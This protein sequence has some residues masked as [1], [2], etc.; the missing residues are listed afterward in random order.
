M[1]L[2]VGPTERR[3]DTTLEAAVA[4][5]TLDPRSEA[6]YIH[7]MALSTVGPPRQGTDGRWRITRHAD[8]LVALRHPAL[9]VGPRALERRGV[10]TGPLVDLRRR[11]LINLNGS[12]HSLLRRMIERAFTPRAVR[13]MRT[14]IDERSRT[15]VAAFAESAEFDFIDRFAFRLPITVI[16]DMLGLDDDADTIRTLSSALVRTFDPDLDDAGLTGA[17]NAATSFSDLIGHAVIERRTSPREDLL[18]DL[19]QSAVKEGVQDL[20]VIANAVLLVTAGFETTMGLIAN[21][22]W[23][24]VENQAARDAL[25]R[26]STL[27]SQAVEETL[28]LES[29]ISSV[30]RVTRSPV[31]I[32]GTT[33]EAG[34]DL[35]IDLASANRDPEVFA[36]PHQFTL[37]RPSPPHVAFGGGAHFCLGAALG[38]LE[39]VSAIESLASV[40]GRLHIVDKEIE[41]KAHPTVHC[42]A[43]LRVLITPQ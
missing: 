17:A 21:A 43:R 15:L 2:L 35:I 4:P 28:R 8:V 14:Q 41:W 31:E 29:P 38:R 20:D 34:Q 23:L 33:I 12:D 42:P 5:D 11:Q 32:G 13:K 26:D 6:P 1:S 27:A 39:G 37:N 30:V 7:H 9:A 25:S 19:V 40:L 22:T 24:L 16:A 10:D 18:S 36:E 3:P